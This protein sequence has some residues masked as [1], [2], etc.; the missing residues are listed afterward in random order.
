MLVFMCPYV[1]NMCMFF[2]E[3]LTGKLE[4]LRGSIET[5]LCQFDRVILC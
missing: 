1:Y 2:S 4:K 5:L 3:R